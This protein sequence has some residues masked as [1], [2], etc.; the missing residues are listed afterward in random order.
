[1]CDESKIIYLFSLV[2][3]VDKLVFGGPSRERGLGAPVGLRIST[4]SE[5]MTVTR[6]TSGMTVTTR[7][8]AKIAT[9][10]G[11]RRTR[12]RGWATKR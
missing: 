12:R 6:A 3:L 11:K 5:S 2:H 8:T 1:M 9:R 4:G 10:A 7:R